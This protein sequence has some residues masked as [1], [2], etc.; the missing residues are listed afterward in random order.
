MRSNRISS[1]NKSPQIGLKSQFAGFF[2]FD[3]KIKCFS[4]TQEKHHKLQDKLQLFHLFNF[5]LQE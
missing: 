2:G 4:E 3:A 1:S 5:I